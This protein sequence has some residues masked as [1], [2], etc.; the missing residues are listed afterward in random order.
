MLKNIILDFISHQN[1]II[2]F[3]NHT[4]ENYQNGIEV[5]PSIASKLEETKFNI[6]ICQDFAELLQLPNGA[7]M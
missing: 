6:N 4:S 2:D 3:R 1:S 7:D 5:I